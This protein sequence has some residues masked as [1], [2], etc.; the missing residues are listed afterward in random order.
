[1]KDNTCFKYSTRILESVWDFLV[2][3]HPEGFSVKTIAAELGMS[4]QSLSAYFRN[5]NMHLAK[6]ET[7]AAA[8]GYRLQLDYCYKGEYPE[9][10][11]A[12]NI[13]SSCGNLAGLE[14]HR[15]RM[16]WTVN[17]LATECGCKR[18]TLAKA[19]QK[20]DIML[21]MLQEIAMGLNLEINWRWEVSE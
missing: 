21:D 5:D 20:G 1:M 7:I 3:M 4:P 15:Q 8:Y 10:D 14:E 6:A 17:R 2:R 12:V 19:L 9:G 18:D 11:T 16:G 13:P